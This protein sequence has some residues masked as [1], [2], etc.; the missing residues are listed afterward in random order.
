MISL[1]LTRFDAFGTTSAVTFPIASCH[2]CAASFAQNDS[3]PWNAL[4]YV[5]Q[6]ER[7]SGNTQNASWWAEA[8]DDDNARVIPF[9]AHSAK[10]DDAS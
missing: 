9:A 6:R 3:E 2:H 7:R 8:H 4:S 1:R 5:L 10:Q